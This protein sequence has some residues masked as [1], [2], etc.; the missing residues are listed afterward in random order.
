MINAIL[1]RVADGEPLARILR[2]DGMP[3]LSTWYDWLASDPALSGRYARAREAGIDLTV[4]DML[5][6]VNDEPRIVEGR[7]DPG[8]VAL[9]RLR[10]ETLMKVI[11]KW[12]AKRYGDR[13]EVDS[14]TDLQLTVTI[15]RAPGLPAGVTLPALPG[16]SVPLAAL[17]AGDDEGGDDGRDD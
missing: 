8:D 16:A 6:L 11:S 7:V 1:E 9:R 14:K 3:K 2:A 15:N 13:L 10:A 12:D 4:Y 5:E 17:P